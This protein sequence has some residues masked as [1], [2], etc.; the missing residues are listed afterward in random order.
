[1]QAA[2]PAVEN[3][4]LMNAGEGGYLVDPSSAPA[5]SD[6]PE[7]PAANPGYIVGAEPSPAPA[8]T[9]APDVAADPS[10]FHIPGM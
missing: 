7:M 8:A 6:E 5:A 10:A 9:P 2:N 3:T 1:M 4:P